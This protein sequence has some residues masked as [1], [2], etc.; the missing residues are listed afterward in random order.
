MPERKK[1]KRTVHK[2]DDGMLKGRGVAL[3]E[4]YKALKALA[5]YPESHPLREE[6]LQ[7]A[8]Q[9]VKGLMIES[10]LSLVV[11]R[12]GLSFADRDEKIESSRMTLA[13]AKELFTR[14]IQRLTFLPNLSFSDFI[15]FLSL[16]AQEP[17]RIISEGGVASFLSKSGVTS[18]VANEI[19]ISAVFTK[20]AS[21][22]SSETFITED[23]LAGKGGKDG[24]GAECS[25]GRGRESG[26]VAGA[27]SGASGDVSDQVPLDR[28]D[29]LTAQELF[30]LMEKETDDT[31][32]DQLARMLERKG[33][34]L[35]EEGSF[36]ALFPILLGL[37]NQNADATR[38]E[39]QRDVSL[40]TFHDSACGQMLEH[41]LD[42]LEEENFTQKE[43]VYLVLHHLGKETVE[44]VIPRLVASDSQIARKALTTAL[45]RLGSP[46]V[47]ALLTFLTDSNWQVVRSAVA[48]LG[49]MGGRDAV[50]GLALTAYHEDTRVRLEAIRSLAEIGGRE[51]TAILLDLFRDQNRAIRRQVILW[52]GVTRNESALQ[53]LL[54]FVIERDLMGKNATLQK[55]ALLAI[56]R[57]GDP[58]ALGILL[59][60]VKKRSILFTARR[61]EMK[62]LALETIGRLKGKEARD[63]L[64][65]TAAR[66][67][68]I[69]QVSA[70]I[71]ENM[72]M[73]EGWRGENG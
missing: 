43:I 53:P 67:G 32:Y 37:L 14:E 21:G 16:L 55:E 72:D 11:H 20:R 25:E 63:F 48:V 10:G 15:A 2:S 70:A 60:L 41:L 65:K 18:I 29:D 49:E 52:L 58:R 28:L 61:E 30:S 7:R 12:A 34:A 38:S 31:R 44:A 59:R 8:Y 47:P 46:A 17:Q 66:G 26:A 40:R 33:Y 56:G 68:R 73:E 50:K 13:L 23:G 27:A 6:I 5:F 22:E 19:N 45:L 57:I 39:L 64:V 3:A 42:H 54:D 9:A 71:L 36:D 24:E 1:S 62:V 4:L 51:A 69:G 35:I